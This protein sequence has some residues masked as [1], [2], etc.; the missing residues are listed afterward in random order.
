MC[1][2]LLTIFL[3]LSDGLHSSPRSLS[4]RQHQDGEVPPAATSQC[5]QQNKGERPQLDIV[6][7]CRDTDK[8]AT[9]LH[10]D[11]VLLK[12]KYCTGYMI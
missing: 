5:Q 3:Y 7:N 2:S 12:S 1:V 10:Q 9:F 11:K 4:L 8:R 6:L